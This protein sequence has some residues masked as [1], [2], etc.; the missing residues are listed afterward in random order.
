MPNS[1]I[2]HP[3]RAVSPPRRAVKLTLSLPINLLAKL[4]K[5]WHPTNA[6]GF[7]NGCLHNK[8]AHHNERFFANLFRMLYYGLRDSRALGILLFINCIVE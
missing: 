4:R 2:R 6:L 5:R 8:Q 1:I 3:R 7:N